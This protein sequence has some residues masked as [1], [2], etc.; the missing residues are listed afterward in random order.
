MKNLI[1]ILWSAILSL[2]RKKE[3]GGVVIHTP[4]VIGE[5]LPYTKQPE[6]PMFFP[7]KPRFQFNNN[8]KRTRGRHIQVITLGSG[9]T[10]TIKHV[11]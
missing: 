3:K 11:C 4:G 1:L 9:I 6:Q 8:R 2:F 10:K 5:A 7:P